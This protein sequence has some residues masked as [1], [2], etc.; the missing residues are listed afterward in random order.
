MEMVENRPSEFIR[1]QSS[2]Q[3]ASLTINKKYFIPIGRK[4][5][6]PL[7]RLSSRGQI[8]FCQD[9]SCSGEHDQVLDGS[10]FS[11]VTTVQM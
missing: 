3:R 2:A 11:A 9:P 10:D 5:T 7:A 6:G 1:P 8:Q 4:S